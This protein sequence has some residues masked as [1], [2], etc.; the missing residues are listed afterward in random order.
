[1]AA[2]KVP[3][4]V[5]LEDRLAFGLTGKQLLILT[6]AAV[7][8]Y[9]VDLL[10]APLL[11]T[12]FALAASVLAAAGGIVLALARRDGMAGDQLAVAVA[13]FLFAPRLRLLAPEGLPAPLPGG[14]PGA[15]FAPLELPLVRILR[16]G[17]VELA[18][19]SHCRLLRAEG[20]SF[21]L[22]A[23]GEQAAFVAAFARFLNGLQQPVQIVVRGEQV[24]LEPQAAELD[25]H[26]R[27]LEGGL[28]A[29]AS[30]HARF[31]RS[32]G[33][34][35]EPLRRRQLVLVLASREPRELV[36]LALAR[37]ASQA[38]ELL[39]GAGIELAPLDGEQ[40]AALLACC[41]D[42]P[43]PPA[44]SQLEGAISAAPR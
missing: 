23:P 11:P 3:A 13:R 39:A 38:A 29:A 30:D 27:S 20:T 31:L 28:R 34:G 6:G 22:R 4:D 26:A 16:S 35:A 14:P 24:T 42:P 2:V 9:G 21:E 15:R 40:T 19:G 41:L 32:L 25:R 1:M 44:G 8:A 5:E 18:D 43:G 10:L 17:L 33:G 7:C 12:P 36:E 37:S